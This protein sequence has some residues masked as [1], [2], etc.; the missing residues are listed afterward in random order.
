M[1]KLV[2]AI[3]LI[4]TVVSIPVAYEKM[5]VSKESVVRI[6]EKMEEFCK[7]VIKII[8]KIPMFGEAAPRICS[9]DDWWVTEP[10][11]KQE[12]GIHYFMGWSF[13]QETLKD[14]ENK[15]KQYGLVRIN[16]FI[17]SRLN[18][19]KEPSIQIE[20]Y[21]IVDSCYDGTDRHYNAAVKISVPDK[22]IKRIINDNKR[23]GK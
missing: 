22:E 16:K 14:A 12:G 7:K 17:A 9:E 19:R 23:R 10:S 1:K 20:S 6:Y 21:N 5:D 11:H 4:L 15:A 8:E 3:F 18:S 2:I 13:G